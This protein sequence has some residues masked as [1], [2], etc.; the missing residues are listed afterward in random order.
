M[1]TLAILIDT[2]DRTPQVLRGENIS[3]SWRLG[4]RGESTFDVYSSDGSYI[5]ECGHDVQWFNASGT[6]IWGGIVLDIKPTALYKSTAAGVPVVTKCHAVT[7]EQCLDKRMVAIAVYETKT[8]KE[9]ISDIFT[10]KLPEGGHV[11]ISAWGTTVQTGVTIDRYVIDHARVSDILDD[12][13]ARSGY[14][15]W[16]GKDKELYFCSRATSPGVYFAPFSITDAAPNVREL[17]IE[18]SLEG[19]RNRQHI[20]VSYA[21]GNVASQTITGDGVTAQWTLDNP[22]SS[23]TVPTLINYIE[24][25]KIITSSPATER[26]ASWGTDGVDTDKEFYFVQGG[27]YIRQDLTSPFTGLTSDQQLTVEWRQLGDDV[28]TVENGV[29]I[30]VRATI[31]TTTGIYENLIDNSSEIDQIG[32]LAKAQA[33]LDAKSVLGTVANGVTDR[34]GLFPGMV[35]DFAITKPI[36]FTGSIL[37]DSV[38]ASYLS[39]DRLRY[40]FHGSTASYDDWIALWNA[41]LSAS[42]GGGGGGTTVVSGGGSGSDAASDPSVTRNGVLVTY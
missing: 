32:H 41:A 8:C 18:K 15:W 35:L 28:M 16:V 9:I 42:G 38:E 25:V 4:G 27:S 10:S 13:A 19:Y 34:T 30:A 6:K 3:L 24:R 11:D 14:A 2:V 17:S 5:P 22:N 21:A 33:I 1:S 39:S 29:E 40:S 36:S 20:R 26:D 7:Y 23:P 31:E 12:L 37:V